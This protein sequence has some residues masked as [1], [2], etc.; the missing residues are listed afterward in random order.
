MS[1][2]KKLPPAG[3]TPRRVADVVNEAVSALN[4]GWIPTRTMAQLDDV[5]HADGR[6]FLVPDETNGECVVVSFNGE[7]RILATLGAVASA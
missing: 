7:W 5:A 1:D 3:D 4:T 2:L 6:C